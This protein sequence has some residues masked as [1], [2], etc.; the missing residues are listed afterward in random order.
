MSAM[1]PSDHQRAASHFPL[2]KKPS[3]ISSAVMALLQHWIVGM[4]VNHVDCYV[5]ITKS[6]KCLFIINIIDVFFSV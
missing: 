4:L 5:L 1:F 3:Y 6:L 2:S